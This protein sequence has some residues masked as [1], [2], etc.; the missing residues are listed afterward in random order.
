ML[1]LL[2]FTGF[3]SKTKTNILFNKEN[4]TYNDNNNNDYSLFVKCC[5]FTL[6]IVITFAPLKRYKTCSDSLMKIHS[7]V[8]TLIWVYYYWVLADL[9]HTVIAYFISGK[10]R[11]EMFLLWEN[12][13]FHAIISLIC[14]INLQESYITLCVYSQKSQ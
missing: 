4:S 7:N 1:Y 14:L 5:V 9:R 6:S 11:D 13:T 8:A 10:L 3:I 12:G 2:I